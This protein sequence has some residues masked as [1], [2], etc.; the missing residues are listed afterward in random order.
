M[1]RALCRAGLHGGGG[2]SPVLHGQCARAAGRRPAGRGLGPGR[3][4]GHRRL[5]ARHRRSGRGAQRPG[6]SR[7]CG[8]HSRHPRRAGPI[9]DPRHGHG[10]RL[11]RLGAAGGAV[12]DRKRRDGALRRHRLPAHAVVRTR[13]RLARSA[14]LRGAVPGVAGAGS[15]R[16]GPPPPAAGHRHHAAGAGLQAARPAS[17]VLHQPDLGP[18]VD[19]P[20]R[21]GFAG[22]GHQWRHREPG[23]LR[24]DA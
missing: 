15:G 10:Q 6:R 2:H 16:G 23:A 13:P 22:P 14:W 5:A 9:A 18:P 11:R 19:G 8:L 4:R 3:R 7:H 24:H 21:R 20:R 17:A 12:V 1:A